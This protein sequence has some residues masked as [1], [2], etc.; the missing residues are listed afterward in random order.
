[1]KCREGS[2]LFECNTTYLANDVQEAFFSE[3]NM[4]HR[5]QHSVVNICDNV[6]FSWKTRS[7]SLSL[8]IRCLMLC[9]KPYQN[10]DDDIFSVESATA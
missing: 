9:V 1:M 6:R 4:L 2:L 10:S 3:A 7:L 5:W 8:R